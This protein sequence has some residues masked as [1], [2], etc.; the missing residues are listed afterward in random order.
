MII[1]RG[2]F[3]QE[4]QCENTWGESHVKMEAQIE[5]IELQ[6][7]EHKDCWLPPEA[8]KR[9]NEGFYLASQREDGL[10]IS[11]RDSNL[12]NKE[13]ITLWF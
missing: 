9:G 5:L 7:K 10:W 3:T 8:R 11:I 13:T 4:N 2:N 6:T 1:K 12:R